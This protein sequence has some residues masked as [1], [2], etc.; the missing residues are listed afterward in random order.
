[1]E[2]KQ[3]G[4]IWTICDRCGTELLLGE[5]ND[6]NED[7][8]DWEGA[9]LCN[10]CYAQVFHEAFLKPIFEAEKGQNK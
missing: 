1:M 10:D 4:E 9:S 5:S 8:G 7:C 2:Q 3:E 6:G